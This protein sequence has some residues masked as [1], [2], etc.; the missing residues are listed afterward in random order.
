MRN[1]LRVQSRLLLCI[2]LITIASSAIAPRNATAAH[3]SMLRPGAS[4]MSETNC[5]GAVNASP[6]TR[7]NAPWNEDDN[8]PSHWNSNL[9]PSEPIP[10]Y[11]YN[12]ASCCTELPESDF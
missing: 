3:Y 7:E 9:P 11:F 8:S 10:Q 12:S 2:L 4:L 6:I 5:V 1:H